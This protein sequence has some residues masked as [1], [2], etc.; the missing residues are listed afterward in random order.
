MVANQKMDEEKR[1]AY[2]ELLCYLATSAR[3]LI[4]E[5]KMYGPFRLAEA[6]RRLILLIEQDGPVSPA[7]QEVSHLIETSTMVVATDPEQSGVFLDNIIE[8]LAQEL[9]DA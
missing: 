3:G 2:L 4:Y 7:L 8:I 9:K 5:P 6:A 1:L